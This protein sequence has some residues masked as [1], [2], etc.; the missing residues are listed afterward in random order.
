MQAEQAYISA[1]N[2]LGGGKPAEA[3]ALFRQLLDM[4]PMDPELNFRLGCSIGEQRK[5]N[6]ALRY[7]S[8]AMSATRCNGQYWSIF[9]ALSAELGDYETGYLCNTKALELALD[10]PTA[11]WNRCGCAAM[12]GEWETAWQDYEWG[13]INGSRTMRSLR[14]MWDGS[15]AGTLFITKEQGIGDI[16]QMAGL[17]SEVKRRGVKQIVWE[18]HD[19]MMRA[20]ECFADVDSVVMTIEDGS[21]VP[22]DAWAPIMSL[23]RILGLKEAPVYSPYVSAPEK[24]DLGEGVKIGL[25]WRGNPSYGQDAS[26]S[27]FDESLLAPLGDI[28]GRIISFQVGQDETPLPFECERIGHTFRDWHDTICALDSIDYLVTTVTGIAHMA[29]AMGK[30][31]CLMQQKAKDWRFGPDEQAQWYPTMKQFFQPEYGDWESVCKDIT[32]WANERISS[33]AS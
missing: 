14:P 19:H 15:P 12:V 4:N 13:F 11:H 25:N 20:A 7:I 22:C 18:V 31:V 3:E 21:M 16:V 10:M 28:D 27:I 24:K 9:G 30:P 29:G 6:E 5:P 26:R 1:L 23:P 32:R 2:L 17:F 8:R 33:K